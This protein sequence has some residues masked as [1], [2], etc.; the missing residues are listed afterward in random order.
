MRLFWEADRSSSSAQLNTTLPFVWG[1][2][3]GEY[4]TLPKMAA[5]AQLYP[6]IASALE[7]DPSG[8]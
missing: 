8:P 7:F 5:R 6:A 2:P 3:N 4:R 1:M